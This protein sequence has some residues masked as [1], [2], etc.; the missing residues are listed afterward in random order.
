MHY[1]VWVFWEVF[2]KYF[3][4]SFFFSFFFLRV[5]FPNNMS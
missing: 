4:A 2:Q 5:H 3:P 1:S